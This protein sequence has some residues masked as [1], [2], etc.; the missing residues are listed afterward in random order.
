MLPL[1][2]FFDNMF[3]A[4]CSMLHVYVTII[5]ME[6]KRKKV[7]VKIMLFAIF[8]AILH[9]ISLKFYLYWTTPIDIIMHIMGGALV[10]LI[11]LWFIYFSFF[12]KYFPNDAKTIIIAVL[13]AFIVGFL[14]EIFELRFGLISYSFVDRIDSIKDLFDDIIGALIA[15]LYFIHKINNNVRN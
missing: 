3:H 10:S 12:R 7:L 8:V 5:L 9:F 1:G 11:G 4:V 2:S 13:I 6:I 14:W 15:G